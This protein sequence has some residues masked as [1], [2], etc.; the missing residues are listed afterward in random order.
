MH[1]GMDTV[2]ELCVAKTVV[3]EVSAEE[4]QVACSQSRS[5]AV[6]TLCQCGGADKYGMSTTERRAC[7]G[8]KGVMACLAAVR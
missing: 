4:E 1:L 7:C 3:I 6:D 2:V 8:R 5:G